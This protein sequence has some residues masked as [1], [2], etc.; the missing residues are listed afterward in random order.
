MSVTTPPNGIVS[1]ICSDLGT[2]HCGVGDSTAVWIERA[3]AR[4]HQLQHV[5][6][7]SEKAHRL[8]SLRKS[9]R[10]VVVYPAKS[11]R[12]SLSLL[13]VATHLRMRR[14]DVRVHLHEFRRLHWAHRRYVQIL[15]ALLRPKVI[16]VST[17]SEADF[18]RGLCRTNSGRRVDVRAPMNGATAMISG[19]QPPT[20]LSTASSH[21][22][23]RIAVFGIPREDKGLSKLWAW[24]TMVSS[25]VVPELVLIG[26]GWRVELVPGEVRRRFSVDIRGFVPFDEIGRTFASCDFAVAPF[27]DGATDGRT[28]LRTPPTFGLPTATVFPR[29]PRDLSFHADLIVDMD[30][31]SV[32]DFLSMSASEPERC[33]LANYAKE[34]E[35]KAEQGLSR[36]LLVP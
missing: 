2:G 25:P 21:T 3:R 27:S 34:F 33:A 6:P 15:L 36:S 13:I 7:G 24:L 14:C 32:D 30:S 18:I 8:T 1:V 5:D 29:D 26:P 12:R 35:N 11:S 17:W 28:S 22:H 4:G 9:S 31:T 19:S 23:P 10:A 16:V 20:G